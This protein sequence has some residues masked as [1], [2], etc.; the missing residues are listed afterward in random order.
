MFRHTRTFDWRRLR[1][2][3][4]ASAGPVALAF[5][6]TA[7]IAPGST[8][9]GAFGIGATTI[10]IIAVTLLATPLQ[11]AGEEVAFRGAVI[12]AAGSWF[13]GPRLAM[14]FGIIVSGAIFAVIHVSADPWF[15]SY[16]FVFTACTA[17]MGLISGGLEAAIAFHVSN[18]VLIGIVNA[19]FAGDAAT[20]VDRGLG[21]GPG[22]AVV[23]LM[24]MNVSVLAM[25]WLMERRR[26]GRA[27]L[28]ATTGRADATSAPEHQSR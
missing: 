25:V 23:I 16:L 14:A 27:A 3:L 18:N 21:S 26:Q 19:L 4:L 11:A 2:Y 12:P 24:V 9:W 6:A 17:L 5:L 8:G 1:V 15:V 22:S 10:T 7:L 13:R 20:V 28:T